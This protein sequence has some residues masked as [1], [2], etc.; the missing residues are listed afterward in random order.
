M[1][2]GTSPNSSESRRTPSKYLRY[3]FENASG[4]SNGRLFHDEEY[5]GWQVAMET[6]TLNENVNHNREL[7]LGMYGSCW[8]YPEVEANVSKW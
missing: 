4:L 7:D 5:R 3:V 1:R 6:V 2:I 8:M